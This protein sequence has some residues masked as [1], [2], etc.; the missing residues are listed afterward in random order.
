M[1]TLVPGHLTRAMTLIL[2]YLPFL[3]Y[4][5][6]VSA[7]VINLED[8]F[9]ADI[10]WTTHNLSEQDNTVTYNDITSSEKTPFFE[11]FLDNDTSFIKIWKFNRNPDACY[12]IRLK[13]R[14]YIS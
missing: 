12:K 3:D 7:E 10:L 5:D 9:Q 13:L 2:F 1:P 4:A 6:I 11:G 8:E 14:T